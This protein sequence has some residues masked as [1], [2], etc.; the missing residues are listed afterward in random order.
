MRSTG[1]ERGKQ[2]PRPGMA[3]DLSARP[4]SPLSRGIS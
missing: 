4:H 3:A 2:K 1:A